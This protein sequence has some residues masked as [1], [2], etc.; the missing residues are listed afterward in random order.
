MRQTKHKH[1][2][3][4][5]QIPVREPRTVRLKLPGRYKSPVIEQSERASRRG[6]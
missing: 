2:P 1:E 5:S 6:T 4:A 3:V